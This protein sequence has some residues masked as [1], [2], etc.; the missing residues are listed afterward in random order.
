MAGSMNSTGSNFNS[1]PEKTLANIRRK[2]DEMK[3]I[4]LA[5]KKQLLNL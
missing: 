5:K 4:T 2:Q 3:N 1:G